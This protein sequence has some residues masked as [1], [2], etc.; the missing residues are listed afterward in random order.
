MAAALR[1]GAPT[2]TALAAIEPAAPLVLRDDL[3]R[4]AALLRLGASSTEAWSS[5]RVHPILGSVALVATRSAESGIRLAD[6][7]E[8]Q[9]ADMRA[10]I[11]AAAITRANRVATMSLLPLGLCFLPAFVLLGV[12]PI[13][14]GV[15]GDAFG[16]ISP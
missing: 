11:H 16:S 10:E 2:A 5:L 1:T 3:R 12:V 13:V 4:T 7:L 8:R 9:A 15:A 14:V 6:G